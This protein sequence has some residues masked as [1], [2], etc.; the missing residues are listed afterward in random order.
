MIE[1]AREY[2][3]RTDRERDANASDAECAASVEYLLKF[4]ARQTAKAVALD[5]NPESIEV[6]WYDSSC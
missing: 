6:F 5:V 2:L 4:V 3:T 1:R